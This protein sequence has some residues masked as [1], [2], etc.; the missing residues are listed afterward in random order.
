MQNFTYVT[1]CLCELECQVFHCMWLS[2]VSSKDVYFCGA[3]NE[4]CQLFK[5]LP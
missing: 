3:F 4:T 5:A 1:V 2:I